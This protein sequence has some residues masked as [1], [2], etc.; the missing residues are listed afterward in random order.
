MEFFNNLDVL[1]EKERKNRNRGY[2]NVFGEKGKYLITN[3][4]KGLIWLIIILAAVFFIRKTIDI[5]Y[6]EWLV[7]VYGNPFIVFLSFI[8]SEVV[9]GILPPEIFMLWAMETSGL[10][11]YILIIASFSVISYLAGIFGYWIGSMLN[12]TNLYCINMKI[13]CT[14]SA[15]T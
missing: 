1:E 7:P 3:L 6:I 15:F 12:R 13:H 2:M 4:V 8:V 11:G 10:S 14:N 5:E 9:F